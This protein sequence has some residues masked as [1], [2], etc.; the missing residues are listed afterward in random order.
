V[1]DNGNNFVLGQAGVEKNRAT[2]FRRE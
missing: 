1:F 2:V